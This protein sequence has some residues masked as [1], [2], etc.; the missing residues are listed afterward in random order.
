[1]RVNYYG[2]ILKAVFCHLIN[3]ALNYDTI[4]EQFLSLR[5]SNPDERLTPNDID[6]FIHSKEND[7]PKIK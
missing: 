5:P 6:E 7:K 4:N 1:M 2:L 3:R